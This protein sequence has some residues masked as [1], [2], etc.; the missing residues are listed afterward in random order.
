MA[1]EAP[2][3]R[4]CMNQWVHLGGGNSGIVGNAAHGSGFHRAANEVGAGDYSRRRDPNGSDG[5]YVNW[6]YACAGDFGHGGNETLRT[7]HRNV[8]SRLMAGDPTLGMICEFIGKPWADKP[9][10]YWSLWNGRTTLQR[11]TGSGHD[12]WSHL[13]WYRSRADQMPNLWGVDGNFTPVPVVYKPIN[14]QPRWPFPGTVRR[15]SHGTAVRAFQTRFRDRGWP[16]GQ[17][18]F[19][20]GKVDGDFGPKME[21]LVRAFQVDKG[22]SN[23]GVAGPQTWLYACNS[24]TN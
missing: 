7:Y 9:V 2:V 15:G 8:L 22:L 16:I 23:D 13:S 19:K 4:A 11:Y 6:S 17:S 3:I 21:A 24:P 12:T 10:M 5:P 14:N 18:S 1:I 20:Y